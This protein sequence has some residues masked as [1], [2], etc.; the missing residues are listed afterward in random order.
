MIDQDPKLAKH[1]GLFASVTGR[2]PGAPG[3]PFAT[4]TGRPQPGAGNPFATFAGKP[5]PGAGAPQ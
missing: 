2:A 4:F 3:N 5:Q 1:R